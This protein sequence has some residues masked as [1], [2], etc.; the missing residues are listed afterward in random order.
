MLTIE[1]PGYAAH[2]NASTVGAEDFWPGKAM[3]TAMDLIARAARVDGLSPADLNYPDHF[4]DA[5]AY[6]GQRA[7]RPRPG[8]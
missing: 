4:R 2:L 7:S 3:I 8:D 6:P 1:R 5:P